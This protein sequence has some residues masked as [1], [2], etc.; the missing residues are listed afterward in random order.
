MIFPP[1]FNPVAQATVQ[2]LQRFFLGG[3][4][5]KF[6]STNTPEALKTKLNAT[7]KRG[8]FAFDKGAEGKVLGDELHIGWSMWRRSHVMF[9]GVLQPTPGGSR[10]CGS[11]SSARGGQW[12]MGAWFGLVAL[13]SVL[14]IWTVVVPLGGMFLIWLGSHMVSDDEATSKITGYLTSICADAGQNKAPEQSSSQHQ[15][16]AP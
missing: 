9:H 16:R 15:Y 1:S 12:F 7:L 10:I 13:A 2:R 6:E 5:L 11:I 4:E 14:L 8:L 3:D